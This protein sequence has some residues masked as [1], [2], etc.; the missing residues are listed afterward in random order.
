M[1]NTVETKRR[2]SES[3]AQKQNFDVQVCARVFLACKCCF[4]VFGFEHSSTKTLFPHQFIFTPKIAKMIANFIYWI[5]ILDN[6]S[7]SIVGL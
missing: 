7:S 5:E 3:T 6:F 1:M 2:R 4:I